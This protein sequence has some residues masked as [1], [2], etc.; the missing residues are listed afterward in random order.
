VTSETREFEVSQDELRRAAASFTGSILQRPPRVSALKRN[1]RRFYEMARSGE[2]FEPEA[3][4]VTIH[5][6]VITAFR[7]P[8][9]E[10]SLRC[11]RGTYVRSV[12]RDMGRML[13]C[14]GHLRELRRVGV[15]QFA[16]RDSVT[17]ERF[18]EALGLRGGVD[19]FT[20]EPGPGGRIPG[21]W[22]LDE[23]L[24]FLPD[25]VLRDE[26][27]GSVLD[28]RSPGLDEFERM[29]ERAV[30]GGRVRVTSREGRLIAVGTAPA[31]GGEPV[32]KLE[33]VL[34]SKSGPE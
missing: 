28:G 18:K 4:S 15:G 22:S 31:P 29:D 27:V 2:S 26:A 16:V 17:L 30:Q 14:G 8:D 33:R 34:A 7:A 24:G 1:G 19:G 20:V 13:G 25:C 32:V 10:F 12:A 23:A 6:F 21:L 9:V 5:E 3:R 11:S